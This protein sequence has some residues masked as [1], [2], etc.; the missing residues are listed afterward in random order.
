[1]KRYRLLRDNREFGPFLL[2]EL[3]SFGVYE[4]DLIW[5][6]EDSKCWN[7]PTEF[8]EL[9]SLVQNRPKK[10]VALTRKTAPTTEIPVLSTSETFADVTEG[11]VFD[12][13]GFTTDDYFSVTKEKIEW[14]A[15][16]R[17]LNLTAITANLFGLGI[18]LVGAMLGAF[19]VKKIV[20]HF[21]FEPAIASSNA[22]EI[23]NEL[24][25]VS[26][27]SYAAKSDVSLSGTTAN[28]ISAAQPADTVR[29]KNTQTRVQT[30]N[31]AVK[32]AV[33]VSQTGTEKET[34]ALF[35]ANEQGANAEETAEENKVEK[36]EAP[37]TTK[38]APSL[39]LSAN[40]YKV[41]MF[42]GITD[43]EITVNNP[44]STT[45]GKAVVEVEFLKPNGSV[46]KTQTLSVE[47]ILP[48][49]SKKISVPSSKRGVSVRYRIVGIDG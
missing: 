17:T 30:I 7:S 38:K 11:R 34:L 29:V 21:E 8:S 49:G 2:G 36:E 26:T 6:E 47:N 20:D 16:P 4:T 42:G 25:P 31:P 14:Q 40:E 10:A 41:G 5:V 13:P 44:S 19:V 37:Q 27:G 24:L 45:I 1:M 35:N 12:K 43:L 28:L 33:E 32:T 18:I 48:G 3:K 9:K 15:K 22:V 46:V 23:R 39:S